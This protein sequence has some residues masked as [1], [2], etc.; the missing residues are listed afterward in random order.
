MVKFYKAVVAPSSNRE[1]ETLATVIVVYTTYPPNRN[2]CGSNEPTTR[3]GTRIYSHS[4]LSRS[5]ATR[6]ASAASGAWHVCGFIGAV[7]GNIP[8]PR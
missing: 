6:A 3:G 4:G 1:A 8:I 2:E 5:L 7:F